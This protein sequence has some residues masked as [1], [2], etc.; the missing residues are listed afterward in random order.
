LA[1]KIL[2]IIPVYYPSEKLVTRRKFL[3]KFV[4]NG[5]EIET[6]S[7]K[8]GTH[9]IESSFD[10]ELNA[11][12]IL[13]EAIKGE[14]DGF[15]AVVVDCFIDP[16]IDAMREVLKIPVIGPGE[17]SMHIASILGNKFSV[18]TVAG[19]SLNKLIFRKAEKAGLVNRLASIRNVNLPVLELKKKEKE[20]ISIL[21]S[22]GK[23]AVEEE[24][25]DVLILGCTELSEIAEKYEL[26]K[27][28][29]V[30]IIDPIKVAIKFAELLVDLNITHSKRAY[31]TPSKKPITYL[32]NLKLI[33]ILKSNN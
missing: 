7:I 24:D 8:Y 14:K 22:E 28:L 16:A 17:T 20:T 27:E 25:A 12:F 23:K 29:N 6:R 31:P 9:S 13:E 3:A 11:P 30:P 2:V 15:D 4:S 1:K 5:F 10:D 21:L 18:I 33:D 26:Q 32:K 19:L